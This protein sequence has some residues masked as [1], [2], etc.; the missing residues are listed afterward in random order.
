MLR[1]DIRL[2]AFQLMV[3]AACYREYPLRLSHD[4]LTGFEHHS[5]RCLSLHRAVHLF[6][7]DVS[8]AVSRILSFDSAPAAPKAPNDP[9][10]RPIKV[11][12]GCTHVRFAMNDKRPRKGRSISSIPTTADEA[13]GSPSWV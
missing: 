10:R 1:T 6:V 9:F 13:Y 5:S 12:C 8:Q 11:E 3:H 4:S 2:I 7:H